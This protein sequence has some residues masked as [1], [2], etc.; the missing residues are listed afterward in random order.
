MTR[1]VN[2]SSETIFHVQDIKIPENFRVVNLNEK[3]CTC[4]RYSELG[5]PCLHAAAAIAFKRED[6]SNY[7][8]K[9]RTVE[10]LKNA[11]SIN[12]IPVDISEHLI[13][14]INLPKFQHRRGRPKL[15][16]IRSVS[17]INLTSKIRCSNCK[18]AG[19]NKRT[20][21]IKL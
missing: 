20:C 13:S 6:I 16:R 5:I 19:H 3:N 14:P 1:I 12:I 4:D 21:K 2:P 11:Y 8:N 18:Q 9:E 17:D 15:N 10:S 7:C